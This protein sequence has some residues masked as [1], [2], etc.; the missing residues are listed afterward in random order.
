MPVTKK[1]RTLRRGLGFVRCVPCYRRAR[2]KA[3][4]GLVVFVVR[5]SMVI[6][7]AHILLLLSG[8]NGPIDTS[9]TVPIQTDSAK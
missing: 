3:P 8:V 2:T 5:L 4:V 6:I 9:G 1:P 7:K